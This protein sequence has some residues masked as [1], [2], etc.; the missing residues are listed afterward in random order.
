VLDD[1]HNFCLRSQDALK[2]SFSSEAGGVFNVDVLGISSSVFLPVY[3]RKQPNTMIESLVER[4]M[5]NVMT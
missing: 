2:L 1:I 4:Q 3:T 5:I